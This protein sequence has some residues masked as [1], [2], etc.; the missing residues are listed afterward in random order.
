MV[1]LRAARALADLVLP[2]ACAG[3]RAEGVVWC[4]ACAATLQRPPLP[5]WPTPVPPGLPEPWA[6]AAYVGPVRAAVVAYKERGR[7]PLAEPLGRALAGSVLAAVRGST[8]EVAV[9]VPVPSRRSAVRSRGH[10]PTRRLAGAAAATLRAADVPV[11]VV[12]LLR[13]RRG[14]SPVQDSAGLT[15]QQRARNLRGAFEVRAGALDRLHGA[16]VVLV[17]DVITTGTSLAEA[18][19]TLRAAGVPAPGAAVVAATRRRVLPSNATR[20]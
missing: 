12:P 5:A 2:A 11:Q 14:G 10:D 3:C 1:I 13:V 8:V 6:A 19:R 20:G 4:T 16:A 17:D 15:A 7:L 18:A 9:L